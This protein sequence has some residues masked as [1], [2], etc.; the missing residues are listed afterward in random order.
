M[1]IFKSSSLLFSLVVFTAVYIYFF[2]YKKEK[3]Q[4]DFERQASRVV[5]WD[6]E[7]IKS[8]I[9]KT[10][11]RTLH[12][13]HL[14]ENWEI[15]S[16]IND[17]AEN[18][19]V[20]SFLTR[21]TERQSEETVREGEDIDYSIYGLE[22]PTREI[23]FTDDNDEELK[24]YIGDIQAFNRKFYVRVGDEKKISLVGIDFQSVIEKKADDL[25]KKSVLRENTDKYS[26]FKINRRFDGKFESFILNK[27][28][29]DW[30]FTKEKWAVDTSVV[31]NYLKD[32]EGASAVNYLS[33]NKK[34]STAK[35]DFMTE[36]ELFKL[37]FL[38][39]G[40]KEGSSLIIHELNKERAYI[41]HSTRPTVY[42]ISNA[43][44]KKIMKDILY[45]RD[46]KIPFQFNA[47]NMNRIDIKTGLTEI[48]LI[49]EKDRWTSALKKD[50]VV[51]QS[52]V[53][54]FINKI[55]NWEANSFLGEKGN[56]GKQRGKISLKD[57]EDILIDI[58]WGDEIKDQR[59]VKTNIYPEYVTLKSSDIMGLPMQ[60]LFE[61]KEEDSI[62]KEE[63]QKQEEKLPSENPQGVSS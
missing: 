23:T 43:T 15:Q 30:K 9:I 38:T 32:I 57:K 37:T 19:I 24:I 50:Q 39:N 63:D 34:S 25:R 29:E 26:G 27:E 4:E 2:E 3:D 40:D 53:D 60:T 59:R 33:E 49:K 21:L 52:K 31:K 22:K 18:S 54:E 36:K 8:F 46:K 28:K 61:K 14:G 47:E 6:V 7:K 41:T 56:I 16:P 10:E 20:Q 62:K 44:A 1:K 35:K 13:E 12:L 58:I 42:E 51:D 45:F 5:K 11:N 17:L 48:H 55:K